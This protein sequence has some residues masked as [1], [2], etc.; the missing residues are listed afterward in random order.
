MD[1]SFW[2]TLS[3]RLDKLVNEFI[4]FFSASSMLPQTQIKFVVEQFFILV[5]SAKFNETWGL[6]SIR[7][8]RNLRRQVVAEMDEFQHRVW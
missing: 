7:L 2:K 3:R 8:S 6:K 1:V 5:W 4:V